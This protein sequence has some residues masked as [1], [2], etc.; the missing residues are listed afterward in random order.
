MGKGTELSAR[1]ADFL[2]A[3][4]LAVPFVPFVPFVV[5]HGTLLG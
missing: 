2:C 5:V 1:F 4:I 3:S